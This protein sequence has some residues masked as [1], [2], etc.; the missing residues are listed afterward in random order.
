MW[1]LIGFLIAVF[2]KTAHSR[3]TAWKMWHAYR[4]FR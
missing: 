2:C 1:W 4:L 3:R